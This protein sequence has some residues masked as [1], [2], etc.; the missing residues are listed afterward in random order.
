MTARPCDVT[1]ALYLEVAKIQELQWREK[2]PPPT[3]SVKAIVSR[4]YTV[5]SALLG[6]VTGD[7]T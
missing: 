7:S 4:E 6:T 3:P 2:D 5:I 1:S